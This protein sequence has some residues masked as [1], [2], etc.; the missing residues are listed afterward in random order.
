MNKKEIVI[1]VIA[2]TFIFWAGFSF[3]RFIYNGKCKH[4]QPK[5]IVLI[6]GQP[7]RIY[8][9]LEKQTTKNIGIK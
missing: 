8:M 4:N 1:L 2:I 5:G 9:T 6:E 3:G 7:Y